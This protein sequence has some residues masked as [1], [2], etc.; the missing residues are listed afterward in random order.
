MASFT[1]KRI[2]PSKLLPRA[3]ANKPE[4][5]TKEEREKEKRV[6]KKQLGIK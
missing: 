2:D 3:F 4:K 1:G 6:V 5:M